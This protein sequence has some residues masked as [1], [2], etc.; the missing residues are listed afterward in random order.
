MSEDQV[1]RGRGRPRKVSDA[2]IE[3][4][5]QLPLSFEQQAASV[6]MSRSKFSARRD[7]LPHN[8]PASPLSQT[9]SDTMRA[10]YAAMR[11]VGKPLGPKRKISDEQIGETMDLPAVE[12]AKQLGMSVAHLRV[13]R[14]ELMAQ[15]APPIE[16]RPKRSRA[17]EL[18]LLERAGWHGR[19]EL[20]V[21][22]WE[23]LREF[24]SPPD[25]TKELT[26]KE[27]AA[28]GWRYLRPAEPWESEP[29]YRD[30]NY[31]LTRCAHCGRR[32]RGPTIFCGLACATESGGKTSVRD[33][34]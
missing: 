14:R 6:G 12:A 22:D 34:A 11:L 33:A 8:K 27:V 32:Y 31:D 9:R 16:C 15:D 21:M 24:W 28:D 2:E 7:Q 20:Q 30:N 26:P 23:P 29:T 10:T 17:P 4:A 25:S 1:S 18:S 3:A 19:R 5:L 13:R